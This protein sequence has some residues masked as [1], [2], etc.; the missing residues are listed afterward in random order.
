VR[1]GA[2]VGANA[3]I[4]CGVELGRYS[5]VGAGAVVTKDV[6]EYALVIGNPARQAGWM[7]RHGHRLSEPDEEGV[8]VCP[9]SGFRYKVVSPGFLR[10]LDLDEDS[11]LPEQL[12]T[13][14]KSYDEFKNSTT[15]ALERVNQ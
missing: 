9:E 12:R 10:C 7:S 11:P 8:M 15:P 4:V 13:G 3:T 14:G 5:F 6:P 1:R 2:T